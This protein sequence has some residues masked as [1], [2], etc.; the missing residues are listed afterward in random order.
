MSIK[1][2]LMLLML[3]AALPVILL[4]G[5]SELTDLRQRV[6]A[7]RNQLQRSARLLAAQQDQIFQRSES[8]LTTMLAAASELRDDPESCNRLL[9]R[10]ATLAPGYTGFGVA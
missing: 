2:R 8:I 1:A 3:V 9:A 7:D 5:W 4:Y 6:E 10:L